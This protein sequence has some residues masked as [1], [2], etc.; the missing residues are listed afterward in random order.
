[1]RLTNNM[2][3][4]NYLKNLNKNMKQLTEMNTKVS[5]Q[6][7]FLK[8]SEDPATA[9]S[10]FHVRKDLA[11]NDM[12]TKT[13]NESQGM[14]DEAEIAISNISDVATNARVQIMQGMTGTSGVAEQRMTA[15]ELRKC[16]EMILGAANAT[17]SDK[18][19]F[20][21]REFENAPFSLDGAGDLLYY[22]QNVNTGTFGPE[23]R[24]VDIGIGMAVD[25]SGNVTPQTA[26]DTAY[27]GITLLGS[28]VDGDGLSNNLYQL[29]G[30]IADKLEAGD[31]TNMDMYLNK[32]ELKS[33]DIR[34]QY[35]SVGEKSNYISFFADKLDRDKLASATKQNKLEEL[36]LE[37]GAIQFSQQELVYNAC[38]QMGMKLLQPSLMDYLS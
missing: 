4:T 21:G 37:E 31:L 20:G 11:R 33:D 36:S 38:L 3:S 23:S 12:Y 8:M 10:A 27:S 19:V 25:G 28:G 2:I 26:L 15:Q 16:Q 9:L 35:V 1:M 6:R 17:F 13:L 18:Y 29:L 24:Y 22:G 5:S 7:K 32:L 30:Q 34:M 14:L